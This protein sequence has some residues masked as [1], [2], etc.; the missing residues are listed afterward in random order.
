MALLEVRDLNVYYGKVHIIRGVSFEVDNGECVGLIGPNGAGKS[1]I[2]KALSRL[3][4]FQGNVIF[5]GEDISSLSPQT[6]VKMG[7]IHCPERRRLFNFMSVKDNLLL[8]AYA[9]RD[10]VDKNL[11]LVYEL[12]PILRERA[13]QLAC[14]L[15]G[16]EAQML[17]VGRSLM[18]NP[19]LLM[20]DEPSLGLAPKVRVA[21]LD[22]LVR[23]KKKGLSVLLAEQEISTTLK[24]S[25]K[26]LLIREGRIVKSGSPEE[27]VNDPSF[28]KLYFGF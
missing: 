15:S 10:S 28:K 25:D 6:V 14:T 2:L 7:L 4:D 9:K 22:V 13:D 1:T 17:A 3:I 21:L 12:F 5:N 18:A 8:G 23:L 24:A 27:I 26:I 19:K 11:K 20:L 16:G